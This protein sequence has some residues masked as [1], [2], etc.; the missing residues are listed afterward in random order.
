MRKEVSHIKKTILGIL[1]AA[2]FYGLMLVVTNFTRAQ[3]APVLP[4]TP[5]TPPV[6]DQGH[7]TGG[8]TATWSTNWL[9]LNFNA[10]AGN[11]T[12]GNVMY[13]DSTGDN[14]KGKVDVCYFQSGNVAVFAGAV[15]K[16]NISEGYFK[17]AVQD[18]GEGKNASPDMVG[19]WMTDTVPDC[20][21]VSF[22]AEVT[23][24]NLQV[25]SN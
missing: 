3:Q 15:E 18:N 23:K 17:V 2:V 7:S 19:V 20:S 11:P 1:G 6:S 12:K 25:H 4:A 13:S 22:P 16:G 14:F 24:G 10:F 21:L 8:V 5:V 9:K